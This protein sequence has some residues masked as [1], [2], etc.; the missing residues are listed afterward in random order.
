LLGQDPQLDLASLDVEDGICGVSLRKDDFP[1]VELS[2]G[3]SVADL[4]QKDLGI[5]NRLSFNFHESGPRPD[6]PAQHDPKRDD[7]TSFSAS[8]EMP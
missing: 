4:G 1:P 5:E 3:F 8:A 2:I 7:R 6:T